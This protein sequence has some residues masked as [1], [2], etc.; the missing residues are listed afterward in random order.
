MVKPFWKRAGGGELVQA[1]L[2]NQPAQVF[3]RPH[4]GWLSHPLTLRSS[5]TP[6]FWSCKNRLPRL[7]HS[8]LVFPGEGKFLFYVLAAKPL[9]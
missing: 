1:W 6:C 2:G 9:P 5:D 7:T 4:P 3:R 8:S